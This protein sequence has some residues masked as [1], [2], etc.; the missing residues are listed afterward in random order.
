MSSWK[1]LNWTQPLTTP[2]RT[3]AWACSTATRRAGP[4][5]VGSPEK[6]RKHLETAVALSPGYPHNSL[7]LSKATL[8]GGRTPQLGRCFRP[9]DEPS[10]RRAPKLTGAE[11]ESQLE[12][13]GSAM[14]EDSEEVVVAAQRS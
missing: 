6:A 10:P 13:L 7:G 3:E 5:S 11:W 2:G 14:G 9:F 12:G 8:I 4:I 1:R